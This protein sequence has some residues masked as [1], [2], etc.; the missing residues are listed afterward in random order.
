MTKKQRI[1]FIISCTIFVIIAISISLGLTTNI[2]ESIYKVVKN[3][4]NENLTQ[5]L[6]VITNLGGI[7]NLFFVMLILVIVLFLLKKEKLGLAI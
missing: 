4:Q 7:P 3:L 1:I 6:K 5:V 2:D